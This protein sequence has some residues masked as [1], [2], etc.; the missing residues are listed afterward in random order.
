MRISHRTIAV[1][2]WAAA[3]VASQSHVVGWGPWKSVTLASGQQVKVRPVVIDGRVK[4]YSTGEHH[5]VTESLWVARRI[6]RLNGALPNESLKQPRWTWQLD[7]W[8]S[9]SSTT[10]RISEL[11]LPEFDPHNSA[12]SWYEDYAAYCGGTEDGSA[13]YMVV[14]QLGRR[15]PV[16]K[17]ELYGQSCPEPTW[18]RDPS[19]V[20]FEPAGGTKVSFVIHDGIAE[21]QSSP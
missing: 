20:T 4:E 5:R 18:Q 14:F 2:L 13:H 10:G 7:G 3:A 12:A 1:V 11:N 21:L 9:V 19:R 16:L 8:M 6:T 15:K 17:K